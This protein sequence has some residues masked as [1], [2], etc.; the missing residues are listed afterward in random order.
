MKVC[1]KCQ[2]EFIETVKFCPECGNKFST[3]LVEQGISDVLKQGASSITVQGSGNIEH[4]KDLMEGTEVIAALAFVYSA[5]YA[6]ED[7][8]D[9]VGVLVEDCKQ[10]FPGIT[11]LLRQG[12]V[13]EKTWNKLRGYIT[14][15]EGSRLAR[16]IIQQLLDQAK[17]TLKDLFDSLPPKFLQFFREEAI[18]AK[19]DSGG[20]QVELGNISC[21]D[22]HLCLLGDRRVIKLRNVVMNTFINTGLGT[23]ACTYVS[24]PRV[25][26]QVFCFAPE[27]LVFLDK[28]LISAGKYFTEP[29]FDENLEAKHRLYH[30][31]TDGINFNKKNYL[32][33]EELHRLSMLQGEIRDDFEIVFYKLYDSQA[34]GV[35]PGRL[36][37]EMPAIYNEIVRQEFLSPLADHLLSPI[38]NSR[39]MLSSSVSVMVPENK[40]KHTRSEKFKLLFGE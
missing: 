17:D 22:G 27:I 11:R 33:I 35:D 18:T 16:G 28:Y 24:T 20:R 4:P 38:A 6:R 13:Q 7:G 12:T 5:Q 10:H 34:I 2:C 8:P 36:F 30:Q 23:I 32:D 15:E 3:E 25:D 29:L 9:R 26:G 37:I 31:L 40:I 1:T 14:T 21:S 39:Q 19:Y